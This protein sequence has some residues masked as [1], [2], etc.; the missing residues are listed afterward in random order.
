[1]SPSKTKG[2][3]GK[4]RRKAVIV[5][6]LACLLATPF[7]Y[8]ALVVPLSAWEQAEVSLALIG[9][10]ILASLSRPLRPLIVFLSGFA[11]LRYLYWRVTSTLSLDGPFDATASV[12]L[13]AAELYGVTVLFL[14][15][16][17]TIEMEKRVPPPLRSIPSVDVFVP[18]Y[19]EPIE[20]VRRTLIGALAIDY[21]RKQVFVLDDGRRPSFEA[22]AHELGC[23]Y[24]TRSD[25]AHAKAGNLN[26]A[27]ERTHGDLI[28]IFDADHVPVRGFL[29]KTVGFFEDEGVALVQAAQHFFNPDPY[30]RNL[31]LEGRIAPEQ[32]FFYRVIQP[33]NDFW[34]SAFF[35]G[36][37]AVVRRVAI[38]SMGGFKVSTVTEDAHTALELHAR[39]WRSVYVGL[40][41][42]AGLS[43]E[44]F[45]AHVTQRMRWA[46]GMAQILRTDCPL[47]KRGL[48]LPQRLNYSNAMLHFFF[49][50]PR[51]VMISA[52]L[53]FLLLGIHSFR[54][55]VLAVLAYILPHVVL[56]TVGNSLISDRFRHSF[57]GE[58]YEVSIAP[59]TAWVTL[60]ALFNPRLGKFNVTDKGT[61][62]EAARFD[63]AT[64]RGTLV[65]LGLSLV[66]L[67]V[68]FPLRLA[69]F[70]PGKTHPAEL[71]A[72]LINALWAL[73]NLT[74]VVAAACVGFDQP[75]QRRAPRLRRA[76]PCEVASAGRIRK[77]LCVD[78]SE[79][80]IRLELETQA[81]LPDACVVRIT[82]ER[83]WVSVPARRVWC[84]GGAGD[85]L[86]AG[87]AFASVDPEKHRELVELMFSD[88]R[89]W[90]K[91]TYPR[92]DPFRSFAY[93]LTT[94]WR[95]MQPR[96]PCRRIAPR[97]AGPW[98]CTVD[99]QTGTCTSLSARGGRVDLPTPRA[100][101]PEALVE[102]ELADRSGARLGL[103]GRVVHRAGSGM[104]LAW[105][106]LEAEGV[107]SLES[108]VEATRSTRSGMD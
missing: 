93:L 16:F 38:E 24:L 74:T 68:A 10:A 11:S 23:F 48:S 107:E 96:R 43:T 69:L 8:S 5:V 83:G 60:L 37:C 9:F 90:M 26:R 57:W 25:N 45:A 86:Q 21:P 78:I 19:N 76:F 102:I 56:S 92:D 14:G 47:F 89:S 100:A 87:L 3:A 82:G 72:I 52:P 70:D 28:A 58:V 40:P 35:C 94:L 29:R 106:E 49:G 32:T 55:D 59:Y 81:A 44:S 36:S 108:F 6:A 41:L 104:G 51:L 7:A 53:L 103:R 62:I 50:L 20:I 79:N 64:S 1:M 2:E 42:A 97:F 65:L 4:R 98:P 95:V 54:A 31:K 39:G 34:N 84:E 67:A 80:G 63:F 85:G 66:G 12:L 101:G 27:L 77:A 13:L 73:A 22:M 17:Q 88:D 61:S 105:E 75:Q 99:G 46:R 91:S 33:G 71:H 30:E 15:Y 18:S